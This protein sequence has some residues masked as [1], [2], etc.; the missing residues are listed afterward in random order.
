MRRIAPALLL[1]AMLAGCGS[2]NTAATNTGS[3]GNASPPPAAQTTQTAATNTG[4]TG[5]ASPPP[6]AQ[7][8]QTSSTL[9]PASVLALW[10]GAASSAYPGGNGTVA[11]GDGRGCAKTSTY[12]YTCVGYVR[13]AN[14]SLSTGIDVAGTVNTASTAADAHRASSDEIQSWMAAHTCIPCD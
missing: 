6:A 12:V 8:T 3:T 11:T 9:S 7:T 14:G 13:D 10:K 5:N 4:S 1:A 2:T